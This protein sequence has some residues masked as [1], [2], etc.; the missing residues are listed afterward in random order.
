MDVKFRTNELNSMA[1]VWREGQPTWVKA[2]QE[3]T[4][5]QMIQDSK[6]EADEANPN[7]EQ[8]DKSDS[9]AE[10]SKD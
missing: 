9:E 8:Q 2:F 6:T 3:P 10:D 1:F 7:D 5:R 4:L